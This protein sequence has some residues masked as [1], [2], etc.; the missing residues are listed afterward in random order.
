MAGTHS[1][2]LLFKRLPRLAAAAGFSLAAHAQPAPPTP[3][4]AELVE[5]IQA[6]DKQHYD[7]FNA[8]D[9]KT[10]EALYAPGAEFY[11]DLNGKVLTREQLMAAIRKNICGK[12]QR[13]ATAP[14][15]IQPLAGVGAI[16]IGAQCFY[17]TGKDACEQ[18]GRFF[19]LWRYDNGTWQLTRVF[20][21]AH[22]NLP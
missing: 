5:A 21:F 7:A 17:R 18:E 6:L 9:M 19:M 16:E 4:G 15:E 2:N 13:R 12:V 20:S 14:I 11:H 3:S 22:K 10:L 1:L 8:C